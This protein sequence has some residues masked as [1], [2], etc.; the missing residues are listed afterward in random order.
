MLFPRHHAQTY[1]SS[2]ALLPD[3][4]PKREATR[5]ELPESLTIEKA[6]RLLRLLALL[7]PRAIGTTRYS[8]QNSTLALIE[9]GYDLASRIGPTLGSHGVC[10][11]RSRLFS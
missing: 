10:F 6:V 11:L 7:I 2:A 5:R 8:M 9:D 1:V 4:R 3:F